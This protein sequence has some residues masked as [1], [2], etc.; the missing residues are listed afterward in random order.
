MT[1][2]HFQMMVALLLASKNNTGFA[3]ER[4]QVVVKEFAEME[5]FEENNVM[6]KIWLI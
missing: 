5:R 2:M 4:E 3:L 6:I 1:E